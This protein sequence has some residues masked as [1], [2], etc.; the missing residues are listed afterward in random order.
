MSLEKKSNCSSGHRPLRGHIFVGIAVL[1]VVTP[2]VVN[3]LCSQ[4]LPAVIT[5]TFFDDLQALEVTVRRSNAVVAVET[6]LWRK[7]HSK[8]SN[9]CSLMYVESSKCVE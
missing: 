4:P 7:R 1:I 5:A 8:T 3:A 2:V 6:Q 9:Q